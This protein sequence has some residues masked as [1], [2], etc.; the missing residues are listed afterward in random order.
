M[1][2]D[3]RFRKT[4][5]DFLKKGNTTEKA[6][7]VFGVSRTTIRDWKRIQNETGKLDKRP[8]DRKPPKLC[9]NRLLAYITENP[10]SY[11]REIAEVFNCT[12]PAVFYALKRMKIT[13]KKNG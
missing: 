10:D 13:R 8:L 6:H 5:L 11:L 1:A 7:E 9:P 12:E 2:Y 3:K 4:V